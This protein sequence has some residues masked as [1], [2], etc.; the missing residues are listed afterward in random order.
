[1]LTTIMRNSLIVN[2]NACRG[3]SVL[4]F[5]VEFGLNQDSGHAPGEPI[6]LPLHLRRRWLYFLIENK[7]N[8]EN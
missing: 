7:T 3:V 1:M 6:K 8:N 5:N 4:F 2:L